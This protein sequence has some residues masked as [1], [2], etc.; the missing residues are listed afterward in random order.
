MLNE[1]EDKIE[2]EKCSEE[3][4]VGDNK[5]EILFFHAC[6]TFDASLSHVVSCELPDYIVSGIRDSDIVGEKYHGQ[7][8][9]PHFPS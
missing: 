3:V 8:V 1:V 7:E 9:A 2:D 5:Q 6:P 4:V